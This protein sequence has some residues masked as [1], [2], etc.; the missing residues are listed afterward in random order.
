MKSGV[1]TNKIEVSICKSNFFLINFTSWKGDLFYLIA[2]SV[3]EIMTFIEHGWILEIF[4]V[5][6]EL[7]A[8]ETLSQKFHPYSILTR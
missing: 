3:T 2:D 6:N 1:C 7:M 8:N 4:F 5:L